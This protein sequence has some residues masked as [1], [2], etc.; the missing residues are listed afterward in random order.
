ML[1]NI[2][3]TRKLYNS[4]RMISAEMRQLTR[5]TLLN[6][7]QLNSTNHPK[8]KEWFTRGKKL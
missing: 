7:T 8:R 3:N 2:I 1:I 6:S 4:Y 5:E